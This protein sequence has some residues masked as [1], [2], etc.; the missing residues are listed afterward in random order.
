MI[1]VHTTALVIIP[2]KHLWEPIQKIREEHDRNIRRWMPHI[3]LFYPFVPREHFQDTKK[4]LQNVCQNIK[5]FKITLDAVG[6]FK[7]RKGNFIL[8]VGCEEQQEIQNLYSSL[9]SALQNTMEIKKRPFHPHL[10]I[11]RMRDAKVFD[12]LKNNVQ[13]TWQ[14]V[15]WQVDNVSLIWRNNSP[16]DI[17]RIEHEIPLS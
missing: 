3:T 7:Q 1:P 11:G 5:P 16:D 4:D 14:P 13:S 9:S 2:P 17:F 6:K 8:W 12:E 15:E 10:T